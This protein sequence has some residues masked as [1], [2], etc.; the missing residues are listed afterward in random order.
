MEKPGCVPCTFSDTDIKNE[1]VSW[2]AGIQRSKTYKG[3]EVSHHHFH[4]PLYFPDDGGGRKAACT[5]CPPLSRLLKLLLC[6]MLWWDSSKEGS[7]LAC[8]Y[9]ENIYRMSDGEKLQFCCNFYQFDLNIVEEPM[10][11]DYLVATHGGRL[12][13]GMCCMDKEDLRPIERLRDLILLRYKRRD[14]GYHR[15]VLCLGPEQIPQNQCTNITFRGM[16]YEI[17]WSKT[18]A[19]NLNMPIWFWHHRCYA[20]IGGRRKWDWEIQ[21]STLSGAVHSCMCK[22]GTFDETVHTEVLLS[23]P[24]LLCSSWAFCSVVVPLILC[25]LLLQ[26]NNSLQKMEEKAWVLCVLFCF[27]RISTNSMEIFGHHGRHIIIFRISFPN[28]ESLT[29]ISMSGTWLAYH[30]CKHYIISKYSAR[31]E[32]PKVL[33]LLWVMLC[34]VLTIQMVGSA[35]AFYHMH[36]YMPENP[37]RQPLLSV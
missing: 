36:M 12:S 19:G 35:Y 4:L 14:L 23:K 29:V 20:V 10:I 17:W 31:K 18:S 7:Q 9:K 26:P 24:C 28:L 22:M 33:F 2:S 8:S 30:A 13:L 32:N 27:W 16:H 21:G 34:V 3:E 25:S 15:G 11:R 5:P 1:T 6:W 37:D